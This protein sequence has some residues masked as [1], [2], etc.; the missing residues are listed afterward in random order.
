VENQKPDA[1]ATFSTPSYPA[2]AGRSFG[3]RAFD[4]WLY[5]FVTNTGVFV[6]SVF[7]TYL[8]NKGSSFGKAGSTARSFGEL[9]EKRGTWLR[10]KFMDM[11]LSEPIANN[12][13]MVFW[14]FA[15][16]TLLAPVIKGF[17]DRR[18]P[19][20]M[21]IDKM[22]GTEPDDPSVYAA[23]PKQTWLSVLGAR[24]LTAGIVAPTAGVLNN[25]N[26]RFLGQFNSLNHHMFMRPGMALSNQL[27]ENASL[28][29]KIGKGNIEEVAS[30]TFFEAFYTSVCT[31]GQYF[32]SR[33]IASS[34]E[35][36]PVTQVA[37]AKS[38]GLVHA[39]AM[40][41]QKS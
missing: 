15:D 3:L 5:P 19:I 29:R 40:A 28:V 32:F 18:E 10:G 23:E 11:G 33:M 39:P 30:C 17:E 14:S 37:E 1:T 35:D 26:F 36:P 25:V 8:T 27:K 4:V 20:A 7:F 12:A 41:A 6:T 31:A 9:V 13:K 34:R 22:A 38:D 16:G 21:Y 24:A 2:T